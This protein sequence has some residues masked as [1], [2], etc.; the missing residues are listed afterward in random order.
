MLGVY[1]LNLANQLEKPIENLLHYFTARRQERILRYEFTA[2]RNR[3]IWTELLARSI[4]AKKISRPIKEVQI[5]RDK[6]GKPHVVGSS[7]KVSL[8]HSKNWAACS[9]GEI[10]SGVDVEE[11]YIDALAIA[12]NFFTA[13]E[14]QQLCSLDGLARAE[15]FL[16]FWTIKE[17]FIKLTGQ[18][19]DDTFNAIDAMKILSGKGKIGGR[20]FFLTGA[21]IGICCERNFLSQN[22]TAVSEKFFS[23]I[24]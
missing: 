19:I 3:T 17:S 5:E 18:G 9:V 6:S 24:E 15:K 20:N 13:Q 10:S 22:F 4:V 12:E 23:A 2:D 1:A 14:Y 8:S 7:L 16:S 21:V 11:D